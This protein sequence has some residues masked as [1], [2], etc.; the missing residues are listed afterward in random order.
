MNSIAFFDLEICSTTKKIQDCGCIKSDNQHIR[1][2]RI[3]DIIPLIKS[4]D[5]LCGHNIFKHDLKYIKKTLEK[6]DIHYK[7]IIDTL[8]LSALLFPKKP[9]HALLKDDKLQTDEL[10]NPLND[11]IKAKN[12]FNNEIS[13]FY[14]LDNRLKQIFYSLL[15]NTKEFHGFCNYLTDNY[16]SNNLE[17]L[18]TD[19][20]KLKICLNS[21]LKAIINESPIELAYCLS[22]ININDIDSI[23]PAWVLKN[24]PNIELIIHQL[25]HTP[26]HNGCDYCN[27]SLNITK[28]LKQFFNYD[29]FRLF[30][31]KPLQENAIRSSINND[32]LVAIFP[33]GGGKSL[34]FQLPA[35]I[36][37]EAVRGLTV[38]I[39]PLQSLMKDQVD[40]LESKNIPYAV[41][42]NGQLDPIERSKSFERVEN[43]SASLLYISPESLR[44]R[45]IERLLLDRNIVRFVID[46]AHCFSS[47]GHDFRV[48]YLYIADFIKLL[49]N[50]KKSNKVIPVSC[51]SATAKQEVIEDIQNYFEHH[52][53]LKLIPFISKS[54]R[55][56]LS[57]KVY[58]KIDENDK[59]T[60]LKHLIEQNKCPTIVYVSRTKRAYEISE[61]L[62]ANGYNAKPY[63]GKMDKQEKAENQDAF[64]SGKTPIIVATSAFGMGVDKSDVGAVIHYDISDSLENYIQE[65]GRAGRDE[66]ITANCFILFNEEDLTKHFILLN[67]TKLSVKEIQQIWSAIKWLTKF[68]LSISNSALEIARQAGWDDTIVEIET[69]VKT[70][71]AALENSGYLKRGQNSPIIFAN[72]IISKN[73][74]EA[75]KIIYNSTKFSE[76]QKEQALR[77][78]KKLFSSK[79]RKQIND[80]IAESRVDHISDHLGIVKEEVI[81]IITLLRE[82]NVLADLKDLTA[83]IK[84]NENTNRSKRILKQH[85]DAEKFLLSQI[86]NIEKTYNIK[87]LN[88]IAL[89]KEIKNISP[90]TFKTIINFWTI[91]NW[92]KKKRLDFSKNQF[93]IV[94]NQPKN[95]LNELL[96]KR[97]DLSLFIIDFLFKKTNQNDYHFS[98]QELKKE[99]THIEFSV[100]GLK[101]AYEK[102]Y[103]LIKHKIS[104][105]DIEDSLFYLSRINALKIDG[106][107]MVIYNKINIT[108]LEKDTKKRYKLE[109]Y[110]SLEQFYTNKVQQIHIVGEY[111]KKMITN[112]EDS[113]QYVNDYFHLN[114][115]TFLDKYFKGNRKA[116]IKRTITVSKF[117]E[118]FNNLSATQFNIIENNKSQYIIVAAGPGSGKTMVLVHKLASLLLIEDIKHEELLMLTFSRAAATEFKKRLLK[119]IKNA[120]HY[121]HIKTFHSYCFDIL[122]ILGD[123]KQSRN[124]IKDTTEKIRN[125]DIE[126][127]YISKSV[128]VI[129]EAQDI[130]KDEFELISVLIEKNPNMKVIIVGDDDQNIFEFRGANSMY[131]QQFL[132]REKAIKYELFE[133][134]RSKSNLVKFNN[135]FVGKIQ[136]R[137][138]ETPI[139][140]KQNDDGEI[141]L[142]LYKSN[143]LIVPLADA[144][145]NSNLTGSIAVITHS[146]NNTLLVQSLLL[147]KGKKAKLIQSNDKFK[148]YDI[149]EIRYFL[150]LI[151]TKN[152]TLTISDKLWENA[153]NTLKHNYN[154]S[155]KIE[156][157]LKI[158]NDFKD[159]NSGIKYKSDLEMFIKESKLEDFFTNKEGAIT[160]STIHKAKGKE[161]DHVFLLLENFKIDNDQDK[162]LLY[163]A[164]TRAKQT[165]NIHTNNTTIFDKKL[166][167]NKLNIYENNQLYSKPHQ[168][169]KQLK[170]ED[171]Y[172][173]Y[174]ISKQSYISNLRSGDELVLINDAYCNKNR[175]PVLKFS[176]KFLEKINTLNKEH[177]QLKKVIVSYI[178]YWKKKDYEKEI[179]IILPEVLFEKTKIVPQP[180]PHFYKI[181]KHGN[182]L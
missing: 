118:L 109:N 161:F 152:D 39:S 139:V 132:D 116:E 121:L 20:F 140:A 60:T 46:E 31:N 176:N 112:H 67:Q 37:G 13:A 97:R 87:E 90:S 180:N 164:L 1:S 89:K 74:E 83:Y 99:L 26:C 166:K 106:G 73:A 55:D 34:T 47:W 102:Q 50:K 141:N 143:N 40:N 135:H 178:I 119:L 2:T 41:T 14:E 9:Y 169:L 168:L 8:H 35:L 84:R 27:T 104:A 146:N 100:L 137:I 56:N 49:Q 145:I 136:K 77:I 126:K 122:G 70:A 42:I 138:K 125:N 12:L 162:R 88:T 86:E 80:E 43:G 52:L 23:T 163:V 18:I 17:F 16:T 82:E 147:R 28:K 3:D 61:K 156:L 101:Y 115:K 182:N 75:R 159:I 45:T 107:F 62:S 24:Y 181:N 51:F 172:L 123:I 177:Y 129:D 48:D 117:K 33:T 93:T 142:T 4:V 30:D 21:N 131:I 15:K 92:I 154:N 165:I 7:G 167:I 124:I 66:N 54:S 144:I 173:D 103:S 150:S 11:S 58:N 95:I 114:Y 71:I 175:N 149:D 98:N 69:R 133:N 128:L 110:K 64:M 170:H 78:I 157:Y 105:K 96:E 91:K 6:F 29:K 36:S 127:S 63:H 113:L 85:L 59:Y 5:F 38:V 151:N 108:R 134:Y 68:K 160:I 79:S 120:T 153:I 25:R 130:N 171:T 111:A 174:F 158:L 19:L 10:N 179:K 44:S 72:S 155:H 94:C 22:L 148:I 76:K 81:N 65:A 53:S 32:S 57:Y